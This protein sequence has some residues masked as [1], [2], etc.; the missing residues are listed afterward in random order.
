MKRLLSDAKMVCVH[1]W[2]SIGTE[3]NK[4]CKTV[5][6]VLTNFSLSLIRTVAGET[7]ARSN[8]VETRAIYLFRKI[9][10]IYPATAGVN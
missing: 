7:G 5:T 6:G 2:A 1:R 10:E 8:K 4:H 9:I 3:I